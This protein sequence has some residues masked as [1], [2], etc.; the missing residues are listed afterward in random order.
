MRATENQTGEKRDERRERESKRACLCASKGR[1]EKGIGNSL[2]YLKEKDG[3]I[4]DNL[5]QSGNIITV[6]LG[7]MTYVLPSSTREICTLSQS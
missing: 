3:N 6:N 1:L 7:V 4:G 5:C 2:T